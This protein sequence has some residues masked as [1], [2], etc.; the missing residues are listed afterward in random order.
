MS[1]DN[2]D[3]KLENAI[4]RGDEYYDQYTNLYEIYRKECEVSCQL[5]SA[6]DNLADKLRERNIEIK[7]L[8]ETRHSEEGEDV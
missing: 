5:R 1:D 4:R 2:F 7:D 6:M 8:Q 3:I